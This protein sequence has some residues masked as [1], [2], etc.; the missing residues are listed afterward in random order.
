MK[1]LSKEFW[2]DYALERAIKTFAQTAIA[3]IGGGSVGLLAI[4]WAGVFSVSAGAAV[5]SILTSIVTQ[6]RSE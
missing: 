3:T 2:I 5:L 1:I 4:D 6:S